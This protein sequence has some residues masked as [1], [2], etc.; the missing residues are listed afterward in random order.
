MHC[1]SEPWPRPH[2]ERQHV[3]EKAKEEAV[4]GTGGL[5]RSAEARGQKIC[6]LR[7]NRRQV[8]EGHTTGGYCDTVALHAIEKALAKVIGEEITE[9]EKVGSIAAGNAAQIY[10][11]ELAGLAWKPKL[12]VAQD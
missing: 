12:V 9:L 8:K 7:L 5:Q 2:N 3:N 6:E 11:R 4:A 10:K 1:P